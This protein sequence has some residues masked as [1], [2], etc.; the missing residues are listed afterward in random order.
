[1]NGSL[2]TRTYV[3]LSHGKGLEDQHVRPGRGASGAMRQELF[4]VAIPDKVEASEPAKD[5]E[6][7]TSAPAPY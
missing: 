5:S 6:V 1:M 2:E 7:T 4:L 3:I